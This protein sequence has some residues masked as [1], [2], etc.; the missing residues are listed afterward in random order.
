MPLLDSFFYISTDS[1]C[2]LSTDGK[3][4]EV[5]PS[6]ETLL[7]IPKSELLSRQWGDFVHP[8]DRGLVGNS[9]E[10]RMISK[11]GTNIWVSWK[12]TVEQGNT[13]LVGRDVTNEKAAQ[14][15][16][17]LQNRKTL[18]VK[19]RQEAIL[20]SIGD[21]VVA[22]SDRGEVI[23][24][25]A[26]ALSLLGVESQE[27]LGK[28]LISA[29]RAVDAD[30]KPLQSEAHPMQQSLLRGRKIVSSS[31]YFY[32]KDGTKFPV[33]VTASPVIL[34]GA[35]IGGVLVFRDITRE[36]EIDRMKTEFISL[37]SHQLR[38]PLSAMKWFSEMLLSGDG[39]ALNDEQKVMVNNIYLSNERMI[40]LVNSLLNISRIESGRIII[41][42]TPTNLK[43]LI[44]EV[45]VELA[46]K[47]AQ[48]KHNVVVSVH[49]ALPE[50]N[51]DPKFVRHVYMNLLTN[52]IKYT[53]EGGEI[54][55]IVSR[56]GGEIISQISDNGYGIPA[57]QHEKVF[58]KFFRAEN[59]AKVETDGTGLGLYLIKS[60]V[61]AS[62]GRIW[63]E[64]AEGKGSTFWFSLP[65][66]GSPAKQGEVSINS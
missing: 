53:G 49:G 17:I 24:T 27:M 39:G 36:K 30:D 57:S 47:I 23:F 13:L 42:P 35:L 20:A 44:D 51:I 34:M 33:A 14:N 50:I 4:V 52:A 31:I 6:F 37:A 9:F 59:V 66:A 61:E 41:E 21:G 22:V 18:E 64:S 46:P 40:E 11:D 28:H 54:H 58:Q 8:E 65:F 12:S 56:S 7:G 16:L 29:I 55:I 38:T 25:N 15:E 32:K 63:F 60:I 2:L 10:N 5:S 1:M 26:Q 48:K 62:G 45:L 43:K 3:I 19:A